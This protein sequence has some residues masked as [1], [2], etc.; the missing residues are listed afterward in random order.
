MRPHRIP[1]YRCYKPKNLG[2]VVLNGKQIYLGTYGTPESLAEYNRLIQEYLANPAAP[3]S[4]VPSLGCTITELIAA[5]WQHVVTYYVKN[6]RPTSEQ[7]CIRQALRPLRELHGHTLVQDFSPKGLKAV[8]Q[9]MVEA[10]RCRPVVNKDINRIK[11][12]FRWCDGR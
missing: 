3:P 12:M 10:G 5:Y 2:L 6:G 1:R 8:R 7:N 9:A 4:E 11:G